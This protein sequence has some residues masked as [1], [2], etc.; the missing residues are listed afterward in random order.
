[1]NSKDKGKRGERE[2][3]KALLRAGVVSAARRGQQ[4]SGSPDSPDV[5][6]SNRKV[7][8]EVKRTERI[9]IYKFMDQAKRDSGE[10]QVPIVLTRSNRKDWLVTLELDQLMNLVKIL[11]SDPSLDK[12]FGY[13]DK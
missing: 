3:A 11:C 9:N 5:I 6:T 13:Y 10:D 7:H 8:F 4:F 2:A 1:M 12:S